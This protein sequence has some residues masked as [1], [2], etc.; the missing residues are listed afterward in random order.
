M[1]C[2]LTLKCLTV[3]AVL[4]KII[5]LAPC[6]HLSGLVKCH[7]YRLA[8]YDTLLVWKQFSSDDVRWSRSKPSCWIVGS[9]TSNLLSTDVD[10]QASSTLCV[11]Q[12]YSC[13][14][15]IVFLSSVRLVDDWKRLCE[16]ASL[17]S[18][19]LSV[20]ALVIALCR[21]SLCY[22]ALEAIP[23]ELGAAFLWWGT[24]YCSS[25]CEPALYEKTLP[26]V[27]SSTHWLSNRSASSEERRVAAF[28]AYFEESGLHCHATTEDCQNFSL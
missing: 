20:R 7:L 14:A 13:P 10:V 2:L 18:L 11:D 4:L 26:T 21:T 12:R 3:C 8:A 5:C 17:G 28:A 6:W 15:I 23:V 9:D 1:C 16:L 27:S 24:W 25:V 22:Q 19:I